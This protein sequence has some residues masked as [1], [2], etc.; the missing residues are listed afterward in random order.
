MLPY[1]LPEE[2]KKLQYAKVR[3]QLIAISIVAAGFG[4]DISKTGCLIYWMILISVSIKC[5]VVI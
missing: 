2:G 1:V 3:K 5:I 4:G